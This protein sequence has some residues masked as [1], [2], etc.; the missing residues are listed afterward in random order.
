MLSGGGT[1]LARRRNTMRPQARTAM[2]LLNNFTYKHVLHYVVFQDST[3]EN[4][5]LLCVCGRATCPLESISTAE[6]KKNTL[7]VSA[8][9]VCGG[10]CY[11]NLDYKIML[12]EEVLVRYNNVITF[13]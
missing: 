13:S 9:C 4:K 6:I 8:K 11:I 1:Q 12:H 3:I 2:S 5:N 7:H 10:G